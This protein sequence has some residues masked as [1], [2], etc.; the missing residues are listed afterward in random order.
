[1]LSLKGCSNL[2]KFFE[3]PSGVKIFFV[4]KY[5]NIYIKRCI[6]KNVSQEKKL[7]Q[8]NFNMAWFMGKKLAKNS[9]LVQ[10]G[11]FGQFFAHKSG[12]IEDF[13]SWIFSLTYIFQ[14]ASFDVY[15]AI[16]KALV[17]PVNMLWDG[18]GQS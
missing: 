7:F 12:H 3:P 10:Y 5:G 16:F 4:S 6:L 18:S 17:E 2:L 14:Y 13:L 9:D 8:K 15:S 11:I 1:M